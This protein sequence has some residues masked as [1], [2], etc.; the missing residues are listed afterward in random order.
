MTQ[1]VKPPAALVQARPS[2]PVPAQ[3]A[4]PMQGGVREFLAF[5]VGAEIYA[6][7][8][9]SIREIMK[10]PPVTEVPR[11]PKHVLGIISVRGR[12]TTVI[13]LRRRLH[14]AQSPLS[15]RSR[16]LLVDN[17]EEIMGLLVDRV[18]QVYRLHEDEVEYATV[19][20]GD[21]SDYVLGIGRPGRHGRSR[22]KG[23]VKAASK[24][25]SSAKAAADGARAA[26]PAPEAGKGLARRGHRAPS[27]DS[28]AEIL[29]LL[30][31][32]ELLSR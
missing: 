18:L 17:G 32:V 15:Q 13:D 8:L 10:L 9:S 4:L 3:R 29:I 5:V 26:E 27:T 12:V 25:A 11:G 28:N 6:L 14:M 19:M 22:Q 30:D 7:P 24:A 23:Q 1:P 2:L 21:T 31:P 16:V 20:G